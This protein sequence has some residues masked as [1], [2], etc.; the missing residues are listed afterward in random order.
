MIDLFLDVSQVAFTDVEHAVAEHARGAG[1]FVD[2]VPRSSGLRRGED[3]A[4]LRLLRVPRR[5]GFFAFRLD[6]RRSHIAQQSDRHLAVQ[7]H[8]LD[9][10]C[11]VG[12]AGIDGK[13]HERRVPYAPGLTQLIGLPPRIEGI[14]LHCRGR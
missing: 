10:L 1:N 13:T 11:Y 9:E 8:V 14:R 7:I 12:V 2:E 5:P 4:P 3:L 6:E